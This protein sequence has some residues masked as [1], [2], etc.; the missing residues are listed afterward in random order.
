VS[1]LDRT[2]DDAVAPRQVGPLR[3][4]AHHPAEAGVQ[5][6]EGTYTTPGGVVRTVLVESAGRHDPAAAVL[7][8]SEDLSADSPNLLPLVERVEGPEEVFAA[9]ARP[10][11]RPLSALILRT[12]E[13]GSRI[14][15]HAVLYVSIQILDGLMALHDRADAQGPLHQV[16]GA[17]IPAAVWLGFG[18]S[19][20]LRGLGYGPNR[21]R[22]Y[23][24]PLSGLPPGYTPPDGASGRPLDPAFDVYGVGAMMFHLLSGQPPPAQPPSLDRVVT[25]SSP[26]LV[27]TVNRALA[28][29]SQRFSCRELRDELARQLYG[30][31]PCYGPAQLAKLLNAQF[32]LD[33]TRRV[34]SSPSD[35]VPSPA[36]APF[37]PGP[38]PSAGAEPL[39]PPSAPPSPSAPPPPTPAP[40]PAAAGTPAPATAPVAPPPLSGAAPSSPPTAP[41]APKL[42]LPE[43]PT[44]GASTPAGTAPLEPARIPPGPNS[45]AS[46]PPPAA[47]TDGSAEVSG[48]PAGAPAKPPRN[49]SGS[50]PSPAMI[51][52]AVAVAVAV[53]TALGAAFSPGVR[54][55]LRHAFIGRNPPALLT[56]QSIPSGAN[57]RLNGNE[58]GR[59]TPLTVENLES[60]IR[61]RVR[62]TLGSFQPVTAT[63][64]LS[65][66]EKRTLTLPF[67]DAVIQVP[68]TS[69]PAESMVWLNG[70]KQDFTPTEV[71][72][73]VGEPSTLRIERVGYEPW[74]QTLTP[75]PFDEIRFDVTL[76]KTEELLRQEALEAKIRRRSRGR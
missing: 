26:R 8:R 15:V 30:E 1:E 9:F 39:R 46:A 75:E 59:S 68:I 35:P 60:G 17:L 63:V 4:F 71:T 73:P 13:H 36:G 29:R 72:V 47:S 5:L 42:G 69:K 43:F 66:E 51:G 64:T 12:A 41:P 11:G 57:I 53:L 18:G 24:P 67:P 50:G 45:G 22:S 74:E 34:G 61:H 3:L 38:G 56:I 28:D 55:F 7:R 54:T 20:G 23:I 76:E 58:T 6:W 16:H 37:L 52:V 2:V 14:P 49:P 48:P 27:H 33:P 70:D 62:L 10:P 31:D 19:V 65:G 25:S 40:P 21:Y 32:A 44:G